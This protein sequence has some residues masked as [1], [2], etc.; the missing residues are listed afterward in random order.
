MLQTK[1]NA[2]NRDTV[3]NTQG[4]VGETEFPA[5]DQDPENVADHAA[6][7]EV[8]GMDLPAKR[9]EHEPGKFETL[10]AEGYADNCNADQQPGHSP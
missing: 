8:A 5:E 2:D 6:E 9:P 4:Q 3:Y 1:G 7:S 10:Q